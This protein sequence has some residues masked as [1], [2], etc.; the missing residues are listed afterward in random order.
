MNRRERGLGAGRESGRTQADSRSGKSV[1]ADGAGAHGIRG[2][3]GSSDPRADGSD[4]SGAQ[5]SISTVGR[6]ERASSTIGI[7]GSKPGDEITASATSGP[8]ADEGKRALKAR[9]ISA[10]P[11]FPWSRPRPAEE[12]PEKGASTS[13]GLAGGQ[14]QIATGSHGDPAA[15]RSGGAVRSGT[16]TASGGTVM[17]S[18]TGTPVYT[19]RPVGASRSRGAVGQPEYT[20]P[21]PPRGFAEK[22][23]TV[24]MIKGPRR[25][26]VGTSAL[27]AR[28]AGR[29]TVRTS[30]VGNPVLV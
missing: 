21:E 28:C 15:P 6:D 1:P 13:S 25:L 17:G 29:G 20:A 27:C 4:D 9:A 11:L 19:A 14:N 24:R 30:K 10:V 5:T 16:V 18:G 22:G 12:G 7:V 2:G 3:S 8:N 23:G 26:R